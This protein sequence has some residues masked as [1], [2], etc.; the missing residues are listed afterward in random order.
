MAIEIVPDP[1]R[2]VHLSCEDKSKGPANPGHQGAPP[3]ARPDFSSHGARVDVAGCES[4]H[5]NAAFG[6]SLE[7]SSET[8]PSTCGIW[9][10]R[11][12]GGNG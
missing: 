6:P 10:G 7:P 11:E 1:R 8:S 3:G 4:S 9:P 2:R 5:V 12:A